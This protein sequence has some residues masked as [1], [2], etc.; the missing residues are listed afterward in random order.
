L[1]NAKHFVV[2]ED[3]LSTYLRQ[4]T[5][6]ARGLTAVRRIE[7]MHNGPQHPWFCNYPLFCGILITAHCLR[8][9]NCV[10]I[11]P[12]IQQEIYEGREC[13]MPNA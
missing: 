7:F 10:R 3:A 12:T 8:P 4:S 9:L 11:V 6:A 5:A 13:I 1:E 2:A